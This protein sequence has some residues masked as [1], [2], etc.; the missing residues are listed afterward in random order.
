LRAFDKKYRFIRCFF[1]NANVL[2]L[3]PKCAQKYFSLPEGYKPPQQNTFAHFKG[4]S[5]CFAEELKFCEPPLKMP[6]IFFFGE[7]QNIV[8][9]AM[10]R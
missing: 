7:S 1:A 5:K 8:L 10:Q 2:F 6:P 9:G 3:A 4:N